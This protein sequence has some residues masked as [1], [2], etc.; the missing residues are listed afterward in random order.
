MHIRLRCTH[1]TVLALLAVAGLLLPSP[2]RTQTYGG[3]GPDINQATQEQ[4]NGPKARIAVA[5]FTDKSGKG[6]AAGIGTGMADMLATA[7]FQTGRYIVLERQNLQDVI[8]EQDLGAS[9]RV[10][11]QSAAPIGQIEGAELLVTAAITEFEPGSSGGEAGIGA[12]GQR[13]GGQSNL[14]GKLFGNVVGKLAGSIQNSHI[15]LD[16]RL[17]DTRTSRVVSWRRTA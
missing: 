2:V 15:A 1:P 12:A 13:G 11:Q 4:W 16:L 6:R 5:R 8:G 17:I 10:R 9:G 14:A 7:L 3:G